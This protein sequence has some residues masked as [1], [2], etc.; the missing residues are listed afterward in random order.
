MFFN[1]F[2]EPAFTN[3]D[4]SLPEICLADGVP[5]ASRWLR[6]LRRQKHE[7]LSNELQRAPLETS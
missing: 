4:L 2:D 1:T 6:E 5:D 3:S 7:D